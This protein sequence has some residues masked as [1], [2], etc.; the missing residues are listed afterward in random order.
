MIL[1]IT[2]G[3][4]I[5]ALGERVTINEV[6]FQHCDLGNESGVILNIN[7]SYIKR[8]AD[9]EFRDSNGNYRHWQSWSDGGTLVTLD[10]TEYKFE[11][12]G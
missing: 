9:V 1:E 6:L 3:M 11:R 12:E 4:M 7:G 2:K 10:G 5:E 8:W